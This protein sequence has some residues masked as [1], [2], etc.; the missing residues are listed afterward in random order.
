MMNMNYTKETKEAIEAM[1]TAFKAAESAQR[2][3]DFAHLPELM[4]NLNKAVKT[5]NKGII[6]DTEQTFAD[7][8]MNDGAK[9]FVREYWTDWTNVGYTVKSNDDGMTLEGKELRIMF[10]GIDALSKKPIA[11]NGAWRS[12]LRIYADNIFQYI[13]ENDK[14][15]TVVCAKTPL[16]PYLMEKR[17]ELGGNW[18][19]H[20]H[21]ALV[22]QLND[23]ATMVFP[24]GTKPDFRMVS[25]DQKTITASIAKAKGLTGNNAAALQL[26]NILTMEK[27]LFTQIY[28]RMNNLAVNLDTGFKD[29]DAAKSN[30]P[31][32]DEAKATA[33]T[34]G[35]KTDSKPVPADTEN[36]AA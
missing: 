7:L 10:S 5:A 36:T 21:S 4:E 33:P 18:N 34:K 14:G 28:T 2:T 30:A 24:E 8:Y 32:K 3:E 22:Q 26:A 19:K 25:V 9:A 1:Q 35:G 27:I 12:Y 29:K 17:K 20:S 11:S 13:A 23:L 31:K 15:E 6:K 16:P